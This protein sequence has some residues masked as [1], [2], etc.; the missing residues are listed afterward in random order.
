M[1]KP[2]QR[3]RWWH[4]LGLV[5]LLGA[6]PATSARASEKDLV[7]EFG[8]NK[9]ILGAPLIAG[10]TRAPEEE[11]DYCPAWF[12]GTWE[13]LRAGVGVFVLDRKEWS[14]NEPD[15]VMNVMLAGY[16]DPEMEGHPAFHWTESNA[17]SGKFGNAS[18]GVLARA[19]WPTDKNTKHEFFLFC[20]ILEAKAYCVQFVVEPGIPEAKRAA[21]RALVSKNIKAECPLRDYRWTKEEEQARWKQVAP[22]PDVHAAL[23]RV[24]RTKHFI[25]FSTAS[26][27]KLFAKKM[28]ENYKAIQKALPFE[29]IKERRLLPVFLFKTDLE[30]RAFYRKQ[31]KQDGSG[32]AGVAY[33]DFYASY[34]NSPNDPVHMH[35]TTHLIMDQRLVLVWGGSW[36]QEGIAEYM[37]TKPQE[38]KVAMKMAVRDGQFVPTAHLIKADDLMGLGQRAGKNTYMQA[39]SL[40]EFLRDGRWHEDKFPDFVRRIGTTAAERTDLVE[41]VLQDLYGTDIAGLHDAWLAYWKKK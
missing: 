34:Y 24:I 3:G 29:E 39:A 6:M 19:K 7:L 35:E 16:Q 40:I 22:N 26:A 41:T 17:I 37:C 25:V 13:G 38:R 2:A 33:D 9:L 30:Y 27:G 21:L 12:N 8:T 10:L 1:R 31:F 28:E 20:G 23:K 32:T 36:Y 15:Q 14:I 4:L 5:L 11:T 18:F